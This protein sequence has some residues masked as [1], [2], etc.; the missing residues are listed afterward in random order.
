MEYDR[1]NPEPEFLNLYGAQESIPR[2]QF[3]QGVCVAWRDGT[4][5]LFL[6]GRF[7]LHRLF[8]NSSTGFP[9]YNFCLVLAMGLNYKSL[10]YSST[11][12][13]CLEGF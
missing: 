4:T 3:R 12:G 5:T 6:L 11:V 2:K 1:K 7:L 10:L 8:K 9:S 13:I